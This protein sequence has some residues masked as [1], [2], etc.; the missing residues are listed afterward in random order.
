[1]KSNISTVI[2]GLT[3]AAA[4]AVAPASFAADGVL[5][6][7]SDLAQQGVAGSAASAAGIV[8][9]GVAASGIVGSGVAASGIVGSGHSSF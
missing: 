4:V 3:L 6:K 7:R 1:M 5:A 9:S 8:G 2:K